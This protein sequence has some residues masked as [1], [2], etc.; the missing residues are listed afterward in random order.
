MIILIFTCER[1]RLFERLVVQIAP[2]L[3]PRDRVIVHDDGSSHPYVDDILSSSNLN[4]TFFTMRSSPRNGIRK[5]WRTV[6]LVLKAADKAC[7][8]PD[9]PVFCLADDVVMAPD[10]S[11]RA[12]FLLDKH[13]PPSSNEESR[14]R[15]LGI[16]LYTDLRNDKIGYPCE[17][18]DADGERLPWMDGF[19]LT[20]G[21]WLPFL[22]PGRVERDWDRF[23]EIGSGVWAKITMRAMVLNLWWYRPHISL[24]HHDDEGKSIMNPLWDA[25]RPFLKTKGIEEWGHDVIV[26]PMHPGE[27]KKG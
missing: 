12:I 14:S 24:C 7:V 26:T 1:P 10:W 2:R 6:E 11:E 25:N 3:Q 21:I 13:A 18:Y 19:F 23:P 9:E 5:F 17:P 20:R 22:F 27:D 15:C 16:M 4:C 8:D